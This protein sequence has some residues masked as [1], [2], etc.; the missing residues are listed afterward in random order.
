LCIE[1]AVSCKLLAALR[2]IKQSGAQLG[3]ANPAALLAAVQEAVDAAKR[4]SPCSSHSQQQGNDGNNTVRVGKSAAKGMPEAAARVLAA[5]AAASSRCQAPA[6]SS[7][8]KQ[9]DLVGAMLL[10]Q[11]MLNKPAAADHLLEEQEVTVVDVVEPLKVLANTQVMSAGEDTLPT[12][13]LLAQPELE[14]LLVRE[15]APHRS[16]P[17]GLNQAQG[18]RMCRQPC[19]GCRS[20]LSLLNNALQQGCSTRVVLHLWRC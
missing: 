19:K 11:I 1:T 4:C 10:P 17:V 7:P 5:A 20:S 6:A 2:C 18:D 16:R 3:G 14:L 9:Q 8:A 15:V 12:Q 13:Q